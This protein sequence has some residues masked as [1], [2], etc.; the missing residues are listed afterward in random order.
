M[1]RGIEKMR[2]A[3][4]QMLVGKDK[5]LNVKSAV[6]KIGE[7][8]KNGAELVI[9]PECFNSPYGT[10]FFQQYSEPIPDGET[11]LELAEAAKLYKV[12]IVGGTIPELVNGRLYNTCPTF[13]PTGQ[14]IAKYRKV[15]VLNLHTLQLYRCIYLILTYPVRLHLK[16]QRF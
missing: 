2:V 13:A 10:N 8:A 4:V 5:D 12:F 9:L 7:A 16:N 15:G 3:I 11:C 1:N 14:L 6:N